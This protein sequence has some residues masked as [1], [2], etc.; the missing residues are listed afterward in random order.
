MSKL[1]VLVVCRHNICRSPMAEGVLR[2]HLI[3]EGLEKQV[4]VESAGTHSERSG[5][6]AD[7][8][9]QKVAM[10]NGVSLK[11]MRSRPVR[12]KDFLK[13]D[14]ILAMDKANYADLKAVCPEELVYKL[15]LIMDYS[16][17]VAA[18]EVPDP[19]YGGLGGFNKVFEL[20]E[21]SSKGLMEKLIED[22]RA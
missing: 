20:L 8:R 5:H 1:S 12:P 2:H 18:Q 11:K 16:N 19:Y 15:G 6:R 4:E 22:L 14:Y 7:E 21:L 9:A 3:Q 13:F 17:Q 10:A